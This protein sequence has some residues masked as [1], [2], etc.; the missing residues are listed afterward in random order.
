MA[1]SSGASK[2]FKINDRVRRIGGKG[3][4]GIIKDLRSEITSAGRH[5][6]KDRNLMVNVQW[7][8]GTLS[9]VSPATIECVTGR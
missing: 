7:D 1:D 9:Y 4:Q 8:N 2:K 3:C 5:E 6:D